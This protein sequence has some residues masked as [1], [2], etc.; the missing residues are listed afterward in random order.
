M[1][2]RFDAHTAEK[3]G[4]A[5]L[6][7]EAFGV[8]ASITYALLSGISPCLIESVLS[9][10]REQLRDFGSLPRPTPDRRSSKTTTTT[11]H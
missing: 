7:R 3:I 4:I 8:G 5:L 9:R 1:T 6:T 11:R 2:R 10:P